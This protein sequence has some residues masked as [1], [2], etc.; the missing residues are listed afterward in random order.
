MIRRLDINFLVSIFVKE[1]LLDQ[2]DDV[3]V[4]LFH[5]SWYRLIYTWHISFMSDIAQVFPYFTSKQIA[6]NSSGLKTII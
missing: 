2:F 1:K 6:F 4:K 3:I 5:C